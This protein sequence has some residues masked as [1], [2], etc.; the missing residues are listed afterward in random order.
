VGGKTSVPIDG[1][2]KKILRPGNDC[3]LSSTY[4][5]EQ[6]ARRIAFYGE[7]NRKRDSLPKRSPVVER[8]FILHGW[9]NTTTVRVYMRETVTRIAVELFFSN[10]SLEVSN[11][12]N[13]FPGG[14]I[15][16]DRGFVTVSVTATQVEIETLLGYL[17]PGTSYYVYDG[18][19]SKYVPGDTGSSEFIIVKKDDPHQ[20][21]RY[22]RRSQSYIARVEELKK[23]HG[24]G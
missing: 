16:R 14:K 1:Y 18:E 12:Y 2:E 23:D 7:L 13:R 21:E 15:D 11:R 3:P 22:W 10:Y 24:L 5:E 20:P 9:N 19:E 17:K 8:H 4:S 6:V